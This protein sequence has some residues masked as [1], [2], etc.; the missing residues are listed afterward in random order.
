MKKVVV[1]ILPTMNLNTSD[2]PYDDYYKFIDLYSKKI[3]ECGAIPIGILMNNGQT[4]IDV[5]E[6]CD[7]FLLPG[8]KKVEAYAYET[9]YY[10][11]MKN[12]PL[13]GICLGMQEIAIF[14]LVWEKLKAEE[15]TKLSTEKFFEIYTEL[16]EANRG[17]I[18][19]KLP[20]DNIHSHEIKRDTIDSA[21]H[22]ILIKDGTKLKEI[23]NSSSINS[24]SL[25]N[26]VITGV[27]SDFIISATAPDGIIEAIEHKEQFIIGVQF[28]P[29]ID[30]NNNIFIKFI[31]SAKK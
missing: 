27:G 21:R 6:I 2:N 14:S 3:I 29:E 1:G 7:A 23:Y 31:E 20:E 17:S 22:N 28:H 24:V 4:N 16:K 13:L 11:I 15:K 5:L 26:M 10:A 12:K 9:I 25:H 19:N 18:L 8:G 30:N